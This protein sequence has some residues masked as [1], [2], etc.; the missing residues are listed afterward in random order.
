[1]TILLSGL[2][3]IISPVGFVVDQVAE[4]AIRSQLISADELV[5]RVDNAPSFQ[6][7][8]GKV[9]HVRM[10]GRGIVPLENLRIAVFELETDTVDFDLDRLRRGDIQL[11][12]PFQAAIRLQLEEQDINRFL[13][14]PEVAERLSNL[15]FDFFSSRRDR[16]VQR[17][18]LQNPQVNF[19]GNS[20]LQIQVDITDVVSQEALDV[21]IE[22]GVAIAGGSHFQLVDPLITVDG[23]PA[24]DQL[25]QQLITGINNNLNLQSLEYSGVTARILALEI[26]ETTTTLAL[27]A[28][29][30]PS[31]LAAETEP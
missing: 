12:A 20:R 5:V 11:D 18:R 1:M 25:V 17:Y 31:V 9:D 13:A 30:E 21:V 6:L 15:S 29:V 7:L 10:A 14:S 19:V 4:N 28:R 22:T 3:T 23:S 27:F 24:P 26:G 8:Q 2:L 16:Q